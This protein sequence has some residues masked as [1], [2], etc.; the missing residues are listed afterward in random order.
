MKKFLN[1]LFSTNILCRHSKN[2]AKERLKV[3][4]ISDRIDCS[5][6]LIENIRFDI[7]ESISKYMRIDKENIEIKISSKKSIGSFQNNCVPS[8]Y[9]NIPILEMRK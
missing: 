8:L 4:L 7:A 3:L 2:T 9:A 6:E 1:N 5:P